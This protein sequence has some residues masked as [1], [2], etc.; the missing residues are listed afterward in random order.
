MTFIGAGVSATFAAISILEDPTTRCDRIAIIDPARSVGGVAYG[1]RSGFTALTITPLND[2]LPSHELAPFVSWL[3]DNYVELLAAADDSSPLF[4]IQESWADRN[5]ESIEISDWESIHV[6]RR[7]FG[8][9]LAER[10]NKAAERSA[11]EL[12]L[13]QD[14]VTGVGR[15]LERGFE[16]SIASGVVLTSE[17]VVVAVGAG[18]NRDLGVS[19]DIPNYFHDLYQP[20]VSEILGQVLSSGGGDVLTIGANAS[21][22]ETAYHLAN[23]KNSDFRL[24]VLAPS[25]N[26][27]F[28]YPITYEPSNSWSP[29]ELAALASSG[30][31]LESTQI[32]AA[33]KNDRDRAEEIG[34]TGAEFFDRSQE[35]IGQMLPE[36][37]DVELKRFV[38]RTGP[39]LGRFQRRAGR[40]CWNAVRELDEG[41]RLHIEAGR[42]SRAR[43]REDGRVEVVW[44]AAGT[45]HTANFDFVIN[46]SGAAGE[47]FPD[48][49]EQRMAENG[50]I[51]RNASVNG[52][53]V[54]DK[55][56]CSSGVYLIGPNLSGN[57]IAGKPTWHIEH[58]GRLVGLARTLAAEFAA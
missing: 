22:M 13:L 51:K 10:L 28:E 9:Y 11:C 39:E 24:T 29:T 58:C 18:P 27:P 23:S 43:Q 17:K 57:V 56:E 54:D 38:S 15:L 5:R 21:C 2:F 41:G 45:E 26:L 31:R 6:P 35:Y 4:P 12:S 49:I 30:D 34:I 19:S 16:I 1:E 3:R 50:L 53:E 36:L 7:W 40:E 47:G 14:T 37:S 32:E 55:L 42:F 33:F 8:I 46:C 48:S 25:G 20:S 52:F 44:S